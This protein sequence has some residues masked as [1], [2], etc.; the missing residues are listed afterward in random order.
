[1]AAMGRSTA[2]TATRSSTRRSSRYRGDVRTA[3]P[4]LPWT[5]VIV[6]IAAAP[7]HPVDAA[8]LQART[9][10]AY[11]AYLADARRAFVTRTRPMIGAT[12]RTGV[13]SAGPAR[14]DGIIRVPGGLVHHW[15][16]TAFIRGVTLQQGLAVSSAFADY[17][18]VYKAVIRSRLLA[19]TGDTYSVLMRLEEGEA[20]VRAVLD[21]RSTVEYL[22]PARGVAL[23][24]S[25]A[26]EIR[27]VQN[28]GRAD[29]RLLPP[30]RDSGYLW[31]A[32]TFTYFREQPEGL[33]VETETIGL[34]RDFPPLLG[35]IIE[36]IARRLGRRSAARSL[37]EFVAAV[38]RRAAAALD[39][40]R[41]RASVP[42]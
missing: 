20:G 37:Q 34:S 38:E 29:E 5:L 19:R 24:L 25:H 30:G 13:L 9:S 42:C 27:E 39:V 14:E 1:M 33:Y 35:W 22:H 2:A 6:A 21:V 31:R 15:M 17:H 11:D 3:H 10:A 41:P 7:H 16:A 26:D 36:P 4:A 32:S 8:E 28:A 12:L 23:A 18:T 40:R